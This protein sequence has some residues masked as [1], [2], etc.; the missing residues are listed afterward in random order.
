MAIQLTT[1]EMAFVYG[2][3]GN[4]ASLAY[5]V[6]KKN[7]LSQIYYRG[8]QSPN[9]LLSPAAWSKFLTGLNN[10]SLKIMR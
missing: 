7:Y 1:Q 9:N 4:D 5:K 10:G 2:N 3:M 6:Q 8:Q